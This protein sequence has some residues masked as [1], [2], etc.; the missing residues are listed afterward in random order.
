VVYFPNPLPQAGYN[1]PPPREAI[2]RRVEG[3]RIYSH[4][5]ATELVLL[6]Y[7]LYTDEKVG[8]GFANN[9]ETYV[10]VLHLFFHAQGK[11]VVQTIGRQSSD[12]RQKIG[13]Q[14]TN[15]SQQKE[16]GGFL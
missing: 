4:L 16:I 5:I 1:P 14:F 15:K 11:S 10:S 13:G 3:V 12:N 2:N 8:E 9:N 7:L 6:R